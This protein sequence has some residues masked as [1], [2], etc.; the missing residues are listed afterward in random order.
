MKDILIRV[1]RLFRLRFAVL[2]P[3]GLYGLIF[4][5]AND[6]SICTGLWFILPGVVF[7]LWA[8]SYAVKTERLTTCGPYAFMRN[9]LYLGTM[10]ILLG[11]VLLLRIYLPG[12]V[13]LLIF[14]LAYARTIRKEEGQLEQIYGEAY[15]EY[16][17]A[18]PS[19]LPRL[20]PYPAGEKWAFSLERLWRSKEHKVFVWLFAVIV[21]LHL[22]SELWVEKES[23]HSRLWLWIAFALV[24]VMWDIVSELRSRR[25]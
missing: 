4:S 3:L 23:M 17:R 12:A 18:V 6:E 9:P 20:T 19:F 2:Y 24:L 1:K 13:T 11:F 15:R 8:N 14:A 5:G 7:R 16:K 21:A 10:L 25:G 22:R